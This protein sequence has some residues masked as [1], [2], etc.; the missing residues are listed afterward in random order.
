MLPYD[1]HL[2][3]EVVEVELDNEEVGTLEVEAVILLPFKTL[4]IGFDEDTHCAHCWR[5][6][7]V[8]G[9]DSQEHLAIHA[10]HPSRNC[11]F[12]RLKQQRY[13]T[14]GKPSSNSG[15]SGR[16]PY[17][18]GQQQSNSTYYGQSAQQDQHQQYNNNNNQPSNWNSQ[19][20]G[21][22]AGSNSNL[23][24]PDTSRDD[25]DRN[26]NNNRNN[27]PPWDRGQRRR[28]RDHSNHDDNRSRDSKVSRSRS[29]DRGNQRDDRD[30][31]D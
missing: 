27:D 3:E 25:Q 19:Y 16:T 4:P 18:A 5:S 22:Q 11:D 23:N 26:S 14:S 8:N 10:Q 9:K 2:N 21:N 15:H 31:L 30:D 12:N 28:D 17:P 20:H 6:G 24:Q 1:V 13:M 7:Q 29:R